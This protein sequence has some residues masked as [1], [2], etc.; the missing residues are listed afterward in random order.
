MNVGVQSLEKHLSKSK[1][2]LLKFVAGKKGLS[3]V[4]DPDTLKK[5]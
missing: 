1:E 3:E 4:G 2:W 5:I